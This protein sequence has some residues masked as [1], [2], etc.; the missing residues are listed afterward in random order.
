MVRALLNELTNG[1][2]V[3]LA[4]QGIELAL[5]SS[6]HSAT[7]STVS[8]GGHR[9][10]QHV[11]AETFRLLRDCLHADGIGA[12]THAYGDHTGPQPQASASSKRPSPPTLRSTG[13]PSRPKRASAWSSSPART[14]LAIRARTA[15]SG[16]IQKMSRAYMA[17]AP[18]SAPGRARGGVGSSWTRMPRD[19]Y[20]SA[21]WSMS[22]RNASWSR[23]VSPNDP[24]SQA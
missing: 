15:P 5:T 13:T 16:V 18:A 17:F 24:A 11:G 7:A 22:W 4:E 12:P 14:E 10:T 21:R 9:Q 3:G 20:A 8:R 19:R 23:R 2:D 6:R 1:G